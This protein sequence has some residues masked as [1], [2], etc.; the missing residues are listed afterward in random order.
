MD[1]PGRQ[2]RGRTACLFR[3]RRLS[4]LLHCSTPPVPLIALCGGGERS[5]GS[6]F[7]AQYRLI[8]RRRGLD[9]AA[10]AVADSLAVVIWHIL[11]TGER[12]CDPGVDFFERRRDPQR[13]AD[14]PVHQ[15]RRLGYNVELEAAVV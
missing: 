2:G 11:S 12:F 10:V 1:A 3:W 8:A 7:S 6:Y 14:R 15:L 9:K 13:E 5:R 4:P